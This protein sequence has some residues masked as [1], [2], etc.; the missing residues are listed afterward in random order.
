MQKTIFL[1]LRPKRYVGRVLVPEDY[2]QALDRN[3]F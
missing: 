2:M 1:I 3:P